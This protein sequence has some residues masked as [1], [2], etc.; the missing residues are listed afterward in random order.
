MSDATI[1]HNFV[2][3]LFPFVYER[4]DVKINEIM[5]DKASGLNPA[6][7]P[8]DQGS[9]NLR[10]GLREMLFRR[11]VDAGN[12][13]GSENTASIADCYSLV[14]NARTA[15]GLPNNNTT[16]LKFFPRSPQAK[17]I[18]RGGV[19][20]Y[21][22]YID[23]VR[24]FLF[25]SG[26]GMIDIS[27]IYKSDNITDY[28]N[29][30]YFI[31]EIKAKE[32]T[33]EFTKGPKESATVISF[34]V[35][36][37]VQ[38]LMDAVA[39]IT[40]EDGRHT[41]R[42]ECTLEKGIV[43]SYLLLDKPVDNTDDLLFHLKKNYKASYQYPRNG[44][45]SGVLQQFENSYWATSANAAVNYSFL[46]GQDDTDKFFKGEFKDRLIDTYFTLFLHV[47]HQRFAL[48]KF[49]SDMA[50]L[51]VFKNDYQLM[52]S[53][54]KAVQKY[55]RE[56]ERLKFRSFFALPSYT[57]HVNDYFMLIY[58]TFKIA[59]LYNS[60][61]EDLQS[62]NNIFDSYVSRIKQRDERILQRKK[63]RAE[64]FVSIFGTIV[65][66][67]ALL[68]SY[69]GIMEKLFGQTLKFWSPVVILFVITLLL[70]IITII[71]NVVYRVKDIRKISNDLRSEYED[72][73]VESDRERLK[74]SSRRTTSIVKSH[75]NKNR[76]I[77]QSVDK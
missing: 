66:V 59:M 12:E 4:N 21:D 73:L 50:E 60:F 15:F 53:Q 57:E 20:G 10:P 36:D 51:D 29:C 11:V 77:N 38:R 46:T 22:V 16:A 39:G 72:G 28:I 65:S 70:P 14:K 52:K 24:I 61:D 48:I 62:L 43:Y 7:V 2:E 47:L 42:I 32:N 69:W 18:S 75:K 3:L 37:F 74:N 54:L 45:K 26:V 25:E 34:S 1:V 19:D 5:V 17:S 64:I 44:Y 30:N 33:F 6:F 68:D 76:K 31:S 56:A 71:V 55:Q 63:A 35:A 58:R 67:A 40:V 23:G 27:C 41:D 49:K 8:I 13:P 9:Q